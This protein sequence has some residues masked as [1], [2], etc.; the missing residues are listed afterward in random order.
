[1]DSILTKENVSA[2]QPKQTL[3]RKRRPQ[4]EFQKQRLSAHQ[5]AMQTLK[6]RHAQEYD[7]I[8]E[9]LM[10]EAGYVRQTIEKTVWVSAKTGTE[11]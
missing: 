9:G 7:E 1:M 6:S 8:L 10:A 5:K 4:T 11:V 3:T 2:V